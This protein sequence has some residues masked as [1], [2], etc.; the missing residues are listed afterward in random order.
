MVE[1][2]RSNVTP[3][4]GVFSLVAGA[5]HLVVELAVHYP[6]V[7]TENHPAIAFQQ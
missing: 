3:V 6:L 5:S 7:Q 4:G 2:A 1:C